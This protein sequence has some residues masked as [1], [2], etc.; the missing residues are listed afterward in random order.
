VIRLLSHPLSPS[1]PTYPGT[2]GVSIEPASRIER[3]DVSNWFVVTMQNHAATHV[4]GPWHFNP[5]GRRI[6]DIDPSE[7][8]F[9]RPVVIDI[10]KG[11]DE[12]VTGEDLAAREAE[13]AGADLILLRTGYGARW[14]RAEPERYRLHSPGF[15]G[16]AGR[17]MVDRLPDLRA[18]AMDFLSAASLAHEQEG[19]EFHRICLGRRAEDRYIF[20]V[21]DTRI[22][23]DLTPAELGWVVMAPILFEGQDGGPVTLLAIPPGWAD[24]SALPATPTLPGAPA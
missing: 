11:D 4:D 24:A 22:D 20:L 8:L 14:R 7:F 16:S 21:E 6:T 5:H 2:P 12:A 19:V 17:F 3:G 13:L 1:T 18:V 9:R 23:A 10:P 15:L